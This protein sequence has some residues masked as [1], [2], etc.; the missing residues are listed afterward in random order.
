MRLTLLAQS[1]LS[2]LY[3]VDVFFT[4][5]FLINRLPTKVLDNITPYFFTS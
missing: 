3:W 5:V 1:S 2:P 4:L